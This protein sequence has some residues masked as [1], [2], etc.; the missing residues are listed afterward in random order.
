MIC[1]VF[2]I[3]YIFL[4][5]IVFANSHQESFI[6][7]LLPNDRCFTA[8]INVVANAE[9]ANVITFPAMGISSNVLTLT[10][11]RSEV[12]LSHFHVGAHKLSFHTRTPHVS[13]FVITFD[14][15]NNVFFQ[16]SQSDVDLK[17]LLWSI[18][19]WKF[20]IGVL[21]TER[22][23]EP[24]RINF[25]TRPYS[26][27]GVPNF[28]FFIFTFSCCFCVLLL[29]PL[30]HFDWSFHL[31]QILSKNAKFFIDKRN[32]IHTSAREQTDFEVVLNH[33]HIWVNHFDIFVQITHEIHVALQFDFDLYSEND[34]PGKDHQTYN[35]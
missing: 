11:K 12:I 2:A 19:K 10:H 28:C 9:L 5:R 15:I 21:V 17:R 30:V 27:M 6:L 31:V 29:W 13:H 26:G 22:L 33:G 8:R 24:G 32:R 14:L 25:M 23:V 7:N 3:G 18:S 1:H 34:G 35:T 4:R 16:E 20:N